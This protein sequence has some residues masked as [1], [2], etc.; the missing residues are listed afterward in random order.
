LR[1]PAIGSNTSDLLEANAAHSARGAV[2]ESE[3]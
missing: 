2:N 1:M 3:H